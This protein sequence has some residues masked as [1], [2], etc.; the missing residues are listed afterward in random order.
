MCRN[1]FSTA[2]AFLLLTALIAAPSAAADEPKWT[3]LFDG[4][5]LAGWEITKGGIAACIDDKQM[6]D[7]D[8]A[9][10]KISIRPEVELSRPFGLSS[11]RTTAAV[12]NVKVRELK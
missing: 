5:T 3:N 1:P 8:L 9:G 4:K 7:H 2:V 12:R 10:H 6:V 11:W